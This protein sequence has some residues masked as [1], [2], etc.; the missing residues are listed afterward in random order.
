MITRNRLLIFL[1]FLTLF[2]CSAIVHRTGD[3]LKHEQESSGKISMPEQ[4]PLIHRVE[5]V[6]DAQ[7]EAK[8]HF[9]SMLDY[10]DAIAH[11]QSG[12]AITAREK[13]NADYEASIGKTDEIAHGIAAM[14][15]TVAAFFSEWKREIAQHG[16]SR[17][18]GPNQLESA[19][20]QYRRL[21]MAVKETKS[22]FEPVLRVLQDQ[23]MLLQGNSGTLAAAAL[24][25]E[26]NLI[27][28]DVAALI[29][30]LEHS[31]DETG[32]FISTIQNK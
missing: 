31:I 29:A 9:N 25:G 24:K 28:T 3:D 30:S 6:R 4:S 11:S 12:E 10:L 1:L 26:M 15:D 8:T 32:L 20:L 14:D 17:R 2:A 5:K 19:Q 16:A 23:I 27:R 22:K 18:G 21:L 7:R 13:L